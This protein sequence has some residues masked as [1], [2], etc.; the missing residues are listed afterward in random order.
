MEINKAKLIYF[1]PTGTNFTE[2][3]FCSFRWIKN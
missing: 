1:S 2:L 3:N